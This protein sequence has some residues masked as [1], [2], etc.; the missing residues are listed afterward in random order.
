MLHPLLLWFLPLA[1]V[2]LVLHL[3]TLYR[4]RTVELSTFR[5]LMES[6]IQQRRRMKLLQWLLMLLRTAFVALIVLTLTRPIAEKYAFLFG[7]GSTRDVVLI[8]DAGLTSGLQTAGSS[9]LKRGKEA[10]AVVVEKLSPQDHVALIRAGSRPELLY[11]GYQTEDKELLR[12]IEAIEPDIA[13]TDLPAALAEAMSESP[14]G[15]RVIYVIS[16]MQRRSW[17][18]LTDHPVVRELGQDVQMVVMNVGSDQRVENLAV[19]GDPPRAQRPIVDFPVLLRAKVAASQRDQPVS[20]RV[21]VV[22]EDQVVGQLNLTVQPGQSATAA[23]AITPK[24]AGMLRGRF[25]LPPDA[26]P[27]DNTYQF[28]LNVEP[29]IRVLLITTPGDGPLEDPAIYLR[30]ALASPLLARGQASEQDENIARSLLV[31]AVRSDQFNEAQLEKTDVIIA[32]DMQIDD[33]RGSLLRKHLERGGGLLLFAGPHVD[34]NS[35]VGGLFNA[36]APRGSGTPLI[37]YEQPTGNPDDESTFQSIG[38]VDNQHPALAQFETGDI[39]YFGTARLYRYLPLV[40][41]NPTAAANPAGDKPLPP[42]GQPSA[43]KAGAG[44][45]TLMRLANQSPVMV[46]TGLGTG[47]ML[48]CSFAATPGWSNLPTRALFV[49]LLLRS[50]AYLRPAAA[51]EAVAS[52]RPHDPAPI[53]LSQQWKG[54]RV[55]ATSPDGHVHP[56]EMHADDN[57]QIGALLTTDTRGY[58]SFR[59][60]PPANLPNQASEERGFVVNLDIDQADFASVNQERVAAIFGPTPLSYLVGSP[61]DPVLSTQLHERH[62]IW[63]WLIWGMFAVIGVEFF[64]A[65]LRSAADDKLGDRNRQSQFVASTAPPASVGKMRDR[66]LGPH[67]TGKV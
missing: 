62:E 41:A 43:A 32:A 66:L 13:T 56:I 42:G 34:P 22:L 45:Q 46:E 40:V 31:S 55:E 24:K 48:V 17:L 3:I 29:H 33:H 58:Y 20:T 25:E 36:T 10:A 50:I 57:R 2:P 59:A 15:P 4:L 11:R 47:R 53:R 18:P 8:V 26:F 19:V 52:V 61:S 7:G 65:T 38:F 67:P 30:A 12:K 37:R 49:P 6:Y 21:S 28:C 5:F 64:L 14:H 23:L 27:D 9:A 39:D 16:D 51:V 63:R 35:Y 54:A 44:A 1:A 60:Q